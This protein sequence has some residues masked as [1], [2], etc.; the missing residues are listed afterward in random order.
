MICILSRTRSSLWG[1]CCCLSCCSLLFSVFLLSL[2]ICLLAC[3]F[4]LLLSPFILFYLF[5]LIRLIDRAI[6]RRE[7]QKE[8]CQKSKKTPNTQIDKIEM[9]KSS[10]TYRKSKRRHTLRATSIM[11]RAIIIIRPFL[12][13]DSNNNNNNKSMRFYFVFL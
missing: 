6:Q 10:P 11:F 3:L 1:L 7:R 8:I 12:T 5:V 2:T 9:I 4:H 13:I